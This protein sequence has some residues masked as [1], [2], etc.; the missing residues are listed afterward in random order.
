MFFFYDFLCFF[1]IV[2]FYGFRFSTPVPTSCLSSLFP[3]FLPPFTYPLTSANFSR[4]Q[5]VKRT[6]PSLS[7]PIRTTLLFKVLGFLVH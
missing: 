7:R 4:V 1:L 5:V 6:T 2:V 3:P